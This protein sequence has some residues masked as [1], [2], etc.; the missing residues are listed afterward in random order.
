MEF[1]AMTNQAMKAEQAATLKRLAK[2]AYELKAFQLMCAEAGLRF[3]ETQTT[4][5]VPDTL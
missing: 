1:G 5:R 3:T 2:T 4:W